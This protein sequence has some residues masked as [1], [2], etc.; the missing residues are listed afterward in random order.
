MIRTQLRLI[1]AVSL[2]VAFAALAPAQQVGASGSDPQTVQDVPV[3]S[4]VSNPED[5]EVLAHG[6]FQFMG[7]TRADTSSAGNPNGKTGV[8]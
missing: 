5:G 7:M 6:M 4:P 3:E 1:L 2:S 8:L